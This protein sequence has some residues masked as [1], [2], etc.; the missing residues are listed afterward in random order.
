[1]SKPPEPTGP[2]PFRVGD[3]VEVVI[4]GWKNQKRGDRFV[5][6]SVD[7]QHVSANDTTR[8]GW[9]TRYKLVESGTLRGRAEYD[10][11]LEAQE[12]YRETVEG[13]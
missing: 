9:W 4:D 5:V 13:R 10:E 6:A 12:A 1:M 11:A 7:D 3:L 8:G 2:N